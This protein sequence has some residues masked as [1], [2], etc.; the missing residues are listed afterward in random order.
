MNII[1]VKYTYPLLLKMC[2]LSDCKR[3]Q[4]P[5]IYTAKFHGREP[6]SKR[7]PAP[8]RAGKVITLLKTQRPYSAFKTLFESSG[9][10]FKN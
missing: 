8:K 7:E 9:K 4:E 6:Q 2:K 10:G 3:W 1:F 5:F